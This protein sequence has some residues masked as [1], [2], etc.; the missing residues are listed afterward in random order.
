MYHSICIVIGLCVCVHIQAHRLG[1]FRGFRRTAHI[2]AAG[3]R[4]ERVT[5]HNSNFTCLTMIEKCPKKQQ[6]RSQNENSKISQGGKPPD[7]LGFMCA[8]LWVYLLRIMNPPP[9]P[10]PTPGASYGPDIHVHSERRSSVTESIE[11][12]GLKQGTYIP[13]RVRIQ[14]IC[15]FKTNRHGY[16]Y[17]HCNNVH[18]YM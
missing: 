10:P 13:L 7:P 9:P 1:G 8:L 11:K 14:Y 12:D 3:P 18:V 16:M 17:V 4:A 2:A 15:R 5:M 6:N